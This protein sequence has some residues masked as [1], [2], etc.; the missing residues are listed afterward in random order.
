MSTRRVTSFG[1]ALGTAVLVGCASAPPRPPAPL[2][3]AAAAI[4]IKVEL[5]LP[6][7]D[8]RN[9]GN[10]VATTVYFVK[11]CPEAPT[12]CTETLIPSNYAIQGRVYL[13][14]AEPGE[15]RPVAADYT[16][17]V[18]YGIGTSHGVNV[19]YLPDALAR[20]ATVQVQPGRLADAGHHLVHA[21]HGVC[22]DT[23]DPGQ[24]R[25]AEMMEPG[26]KKCGL[27][28]IVA[29]EMLHLYRALRRQVVIGN[30]A[31]PMGTI[32]NHFR[33]VSHTTFAGASNRQTLEDAREDLA[34]SGWWID[35]QPPVQPSQGR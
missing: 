24:L 1:M 4:T 6:V 18:Y 34:P 2:S 32:P 27:L 9:S 26:T 28:A 19:T 3:P 20:T 33:G 13:L 12:S 16:T 31:Y 17:A 8:W 7:H 29:D 21:T 22:P 10:A 11:A 23:A 35:G 15:Y 5:R 30:K 25:Y 14:N